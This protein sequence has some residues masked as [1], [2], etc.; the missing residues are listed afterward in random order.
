MSAVLYAMIG[1]PCA[2]KT[3]YAKALE[4]RTGA[5]RFTPDEWHTYLFGHDMDNP[6][7]DA[8][9]DRVEELM[10]SVADRLLKSGASVI[11]DFGFWGRSQ[12]DELRE[13]AKS[14]G[15][16][17]EMHYMD[18]DIEEIF[19][20][21]EARN[22]SGREDIFHITRADMETWL[23]WWEPPTDDEVGLIRITTDKTNGDNA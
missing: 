11:L 15:A 7:H 21:I 13:Y 9:H 10:R 1:L 18:T 12:R 22:A 17:F 2:G 5:V 19:R 8:R 6:D 4:A 14:L 3:T 23:T 20:R 16:G